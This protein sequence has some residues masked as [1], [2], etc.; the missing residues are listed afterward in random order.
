MIAN[1]GLAAQND[2]TA[3]SLPVTR[4]SSP[5][6][7]LGVS[8]SATYDITYSIVSLKCLEFMSG[9]VPKGH[10]TIAQGFNLGWAIPS[11]TSPEGTAAMIGHGISTSRTGKHDKT[12]AIFAI[13]FAS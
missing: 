4:A 3:S 6:S 8:P 9:F 13:P 5:A 7:S 12:T 1:F 10:A 2:T 11:T